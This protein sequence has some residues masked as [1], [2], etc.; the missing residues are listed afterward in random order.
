LAFFVD[1]A[2]FVA[3]IAPCETARNA[4]ASGAILSHRSSCTHHLFPRAIQMVSLIT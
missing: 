1:F 3:T 2:V 4:R